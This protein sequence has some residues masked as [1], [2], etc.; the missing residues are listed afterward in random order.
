MAYYTGTVSTMV[1]LKTVI[2][3]Q[4]VVGGWTLASGVLSKGLSHI[5]LTNP[6]NLQIDIT[7]ANSADFLTE[8]AGFSRCIYVDTPDYPLT[9]YLFVHTNPDMVVCVVNFQTDTIQTLFFGDIVKLD[10]AAYVGGNLFF[11]SGYSPNP[12]YRS[13]LWY[14][15]DDGIGGTDNQNDT[16]PAHDANFFMP[17]LTEWSNTN[18]GNGFHAKIDGNIWDSSSNV[19]CLDTTIA[20][21]HRSPNLWDS[22]AHLIPLHLQFKMLDSLFGYLGYID[23]IRLIKINNYNIGDI[24]TISPDKW[25]V[26]PWYRKELTRPNGNSSVSQVD[27]QAALNGSG[28][29]G[30]AVRYDGP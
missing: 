4:A 24:V 9:Y 10:N 17:F 18:S 5:K 14:L 15:T 22:Q 16:Q 28:G 27:E 25:K 3:T 30:F 6:D 7:G 26:F 13:C 29:L 12:T 19:M 1:E 11:A 21:Y 2:E 23:H 8:P 20:N